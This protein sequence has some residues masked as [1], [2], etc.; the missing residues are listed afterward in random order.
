LSGDARDRSRA[1][2]HHRRRRSRR[3][4]ALVKDCG[5]KQGGVRG[6]TAKVDVLIKNPRTHFGELFGVNRI[7]AEQAFALVKNDP[8]TYPKS[9]QDGM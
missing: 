1:R 2:H 3:A 7:Y 8:P 4:R 6:K 5:Q 9:R